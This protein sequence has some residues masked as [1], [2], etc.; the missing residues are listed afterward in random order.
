MRTH[1][2][3]AGY[4]PF[5]PL[6]DDFRAYAQKNIRKIYTTFKQ[7]VAAGRNLSLEK[8]ESLAQGRVWSGKEALA[9]GLVDALGG[10]DEAIDAA[11]SQ[12]N[13]EKYNCIA[14]PRWDKDLESIINQL[15]PTLKYEGLLKIL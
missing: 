14:Y 12:A 2:S 3:A 10:L 9:N 7:R 11:A 15:I 8:V 1:T 5:E 13:L 6:S 4:S